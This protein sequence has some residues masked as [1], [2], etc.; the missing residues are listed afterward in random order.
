MLRLPACVAEV[1]DRLLGAA[2]EHE[3]CLLP[4]AILKIADVLIGIVIDDP[5]RRPGF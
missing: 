1:Q 4:K 5:R 3:Q 2:V